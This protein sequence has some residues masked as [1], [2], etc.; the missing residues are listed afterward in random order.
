MEFWNIM[1]AVFTIVGIV[2]MS[3]FYSEMVGNKWVLNKIS[4]KAFWITLLACLSMAV[5]SALA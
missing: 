5:S 1:V 4:T 2:G 3:V